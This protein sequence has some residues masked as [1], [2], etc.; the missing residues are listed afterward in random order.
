[1]AVGVLSIVEPSPVRIQS[2]G[3]H[4]FDASALTAGPQGHLGMVF[5]LMHACGVGELGELGE[6]G[7]ESL[8]VLGAAS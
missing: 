6:L 3:F 8:A 5:L 4:L 7:V 2:H 1:M